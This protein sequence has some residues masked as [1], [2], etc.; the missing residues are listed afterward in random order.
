MFYFSTVRNIA[1][2]LLSSL[3][4]SLHLFYLHS[5]CY[6]LHCFP[7]SI[8][9]FF[10]AHLLSITLS[11]AR[12]L[13]SLV[14]SLHPCFVRS[15]HSSL[16]QLGEER[17]T[18]SSPARQQRTS[19]VPQAEGKTKIILFAEIYSRNIS[20]GEGSYLQETRK[21]IYK[22]KPCEDKGFL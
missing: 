1:L 20:S 2:M 14:L 12:S 19:I 4:Y 16:I 8:P 9:L 17:C 22:K 18:T 11:L 13:P 6:Y 5:F 21:K 7:L 15:L 3:C 10:F